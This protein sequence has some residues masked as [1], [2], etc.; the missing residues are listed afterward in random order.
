MDNKIWMLACFKPYILVEDEDYREQQQ[1]QQ[2]EFSLCPV[3]DD[4]LSGPW[5]PRPEAEGDGPEGAASSQLSGR[6]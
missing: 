3:A 5:K 6:E 4:S 1:L 2:H